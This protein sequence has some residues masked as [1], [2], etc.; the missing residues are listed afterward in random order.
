MM[1]EMT[2]TYLTIPAQGKKNVVL[3]EP[4][5]RRMVSLCDRTPKPE[6]AG[7]TR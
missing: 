6:T 5:S 4:H 2:T 7:L 3:R 1:S